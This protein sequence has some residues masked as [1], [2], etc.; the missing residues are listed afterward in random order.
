MPSLLI[1]PAIL[2]ITLWTDKHHGLIR[3]N[4]SLNLE[5]PFSTI[6]KT[7]GP[8]YWVFSAYSYTVIMITLS[9]IFIS[10]MEKNRINKYQL[11]SLFIGVFVPAFTTLVNVSGLTPL[12]FDVTPHAMGISMAA[13]FYGV[14][15]HHLFDVIPVTR[16]KIID[17]MDTGVMVLDSDGKIM[18]INMACAEIFEVKPQLIYGSDARTVFAVHDEL[19]DMFLKKDVGG[20]RSFTADNGGG[21]TYYE[22]SFAQLVDKKDRL[23]GWLY[24]FVNVTSNR[25][26]ENRIYHLAF[27][28]HLTGLVNRQMFYD[29]FAKELLNARVEEFFIVLCLINIDNFKK[30]NEEFGHEEGDR[31]IRE[32]ARRLK[33]VVR[34]SDIVARVGADEYAVVLNG[35]IDITDIPILTQRIHDVFLDNYMILNSL[36]TITGSVGVS[37]FPTDAHNADEMMRKAD[38]ALTKAKKAG[39]NK[40]EIYLDS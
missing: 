35:I 31:V 29:I 25:K 19:Y 36:Y 23:M 8:L 17:E 32:T 4:V 14:F 33:N 12:K 26:A 1:V 24:L 10:V 27:Y 15:R 9:L 40:I 13:I 5:G 39:K 20:I 6:S 21:L 18:D 3:Q 38:Q 28:D 30:I 11:I 34:G 22:A 2:N 37:V 16:A 7:F